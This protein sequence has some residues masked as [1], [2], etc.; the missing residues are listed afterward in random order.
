MRS[1][2][3][4][5]KIGNMALSGERKFTLGNHGFRVALKTL[6]TRG[7]HLDGVTRGKI[8]QFSS[9]SA[10]RL[11]EA[12]F[13]LSIEHSTVVGITLTVPWHADDF[14]PL[15]AEWR[16]VFKRFRAGFEYR[17]PSSA[18]IYRNELQRRGAPHIHAVCYLAH[19]DLQ[20]KQM[21][22]EKSGGARQ[23]VKSQQPY[24]LEL[25]KHIH[26]PN[27]VELCQPLHAAFQTLEG[28]WLQSVGKNLHGG[29]MRDFQLHGVKFDVLDASDCGN[30]FRY[31][32][33]HSSKHKTDQ[34]GYAGKQW[35]FIGR[36]N[37]DS[38]SVTNLPPFISDKHEAIFWRMIRKLTRYRLDHSL[39]TEWSKNHPYKDANH[40][41]WW[42]IKGGVWHRSPPFDCVYKGGHRR[43]G[44]VFV[45]G[46]RDTVIKAFDFAMHQAREA[47]R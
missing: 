44:V 12:L 4:V 38:S 29:S 33:D 20:S 32:A 40:P 19:S 1:I 41:Q 47:T 34:L 7:S 36:Q 31:L 22:A 43:L 3:N 26:S 23:S 15:M 37:L 2:S 30:L 9:S 6:K 18:I 11:R 27:F 16:Q 45:P 39:G 42:F 35:G 46:G 21:E 17:F 10:R 28:L 24:A 13:S 5:K 14:E 25:S 8:T